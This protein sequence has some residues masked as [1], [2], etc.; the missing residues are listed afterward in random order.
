MLHTSAV[1][2][3]HDR[4]GGRAPHSSAPVA[5]TISR[6]AIDLHPHGEELLG[7]PPAS[8]DHAV[9]PM[10]EGE[11]GEPRIPGR[12]RPG[13]E[14]VG[15]EI[16]SLLL[17]LAGKW[18]DTGVLWTSRAPTLGPGSSCPAQLQPLVLPQPSQT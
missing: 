6:L 18:M 4:A 14:E 11:V 1:V 8:D 2:E 16:A 10:V 5:G 3:R 12:G 15:D 17:S 9:E 7:V 13:L